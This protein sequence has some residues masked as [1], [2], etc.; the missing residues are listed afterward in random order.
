M[1]TDISD[2]AVRYDRLLPSNSSW[3]TFTSCADGLTH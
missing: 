3:A 1:P 2:N